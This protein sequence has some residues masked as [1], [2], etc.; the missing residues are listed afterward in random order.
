[1]NENPN[2]LSNEPVPDGGARHSIKSYP[3]KKLSFVRFL[4]QTQRKVEVIWINYEG[5]RVRYKTLE[6][7]DYFDVNTYVAHPWVF[8]DAKTREYLLVDSKDIY[9]PGPWYEV[10]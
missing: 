9:E 10:H 6:P 2:I 3:N 1:M 4:N 8:Q 5:A 7:Q